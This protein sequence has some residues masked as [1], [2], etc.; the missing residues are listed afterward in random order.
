[1]R[2][3]RLTAG[4]IS[5]GAFVVYCLTLA[6][7]VGFIDSGELSAVAATLGVAHPTG[8]P[9]F[10][11][12]GWLVAHAPLPGTVILRLNIFAALC[13]AGGVFVFYH[14]VRRVILAATGRGEETWRV[15]PAAAAAA[16][17]MAFSETWWS[18]AVAVE[19]YPLHILLVCLILFTFLRANS[20]LPGEQE[21]D[22]WW[23]LFAFLVGLSFANHMTTVLLAPGLIVLYFLRQGSTI[24]SWRLLFRMVLPFAA[25]LSVVLY[26]PLRALQSPVLNWGD[27]SNL[28]RFLWHVTGKQYRAWIF[29]SAEVAD[30]QIAY[31]LRSFPPEFAYVGAV[32]AVPGL[33]LLWSWNRQLAMGT[34]LLFVVCVLY[35]INYDIHDIDSYFLLAYICT[36]LWAGVG[37]HAVWKAVAGSGRVRRFAAT[38]AVIVAGAVPLGV[39]YSRVDRSA[40]HLVEDYTQNMFASLDSNA[41]VLSFQ[42]DYWVSASYE[43][44]LVERVRP[45]VIV[46][47]K[48]LL[49]RSWYVREL[50]KRYPW[51]LAG[52][53]KEFDAFL[54]EVSR[55]EHDLP[56]DGGILEARYAGLIGAIIRTAIASRPVYVTAEMQWQYTRGYRRVPSGLAFRLRE[57]DVFFP[58]TFPEYRFRPFLSSGRWERTVPRLYAESLAARGEYYLVAGKDRPEASKCLEKAMEFDSSS[59]VVQ[60]FSGILRAAR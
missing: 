2:T 30:R 4:G 52:A 44:Q 28:E 32:A 27:P 25:G 15:T 10:T 55:F 38:A 26:L 14:V 31:F 3:S 36:A 29:S 22:I 47:D 37:L 39:N 11:L 7:G 18:Q 48:E 46:I 49:R 23:Y 20:P 58:T 42:W 13:C 6:P 35:A 45:D 60:R 21:T 33:A 54:T 8:Y 51:I 53:Q 50:G 12:L 57:D 9:L 56:Y 1:M 17:L 24:T 59:P 16:M 5:V 43:V 41:V 34:L 40:D 19:V